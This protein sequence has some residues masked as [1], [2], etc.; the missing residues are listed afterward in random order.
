MDEETKSNLD[1]WV[2]EYPNC[3]NLIKNSG[4]T[5]A[6]GRKPPPKGDNPKWSYLEKLLN[7]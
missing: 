5:K 2:S 1:Q 6:F 4:L 7:R 3:A